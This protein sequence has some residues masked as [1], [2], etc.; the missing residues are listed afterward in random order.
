MSKPGMAV[1]IIPERRRCT[2]CRRWYR[3]N[4]HCAHNQKT[5]GRRQ[6]RLGR[7]N[8]LARRRREGEL[9]VYRSQE[10]ERQ[11]R[12][13]AALKAEQRTGQKQPAQPMSRAGVIPQQA[14]ILAKILQEWDTAAHLSRA[15]FRR[16]LPRIM[17][18]IGQDLG[19]ADP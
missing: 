19:Q 4:R 17:R 15:G 11:R 12:R 9:A 2:E 16:Q 13:R 7:H 18:E 8:R 6:C 1:Q 5:C 10:R 3:P 14:E